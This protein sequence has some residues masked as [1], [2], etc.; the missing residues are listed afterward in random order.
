MIINS[1]FNKFV[2]TFP[3]RVSSFQIRY[4]YWLY[5]YYYYYSLE[6]GQRYTYNIERDE[7]VFT[8]PMEVCKD[9]CRMRV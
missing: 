9:I 2:Y 6:G 3:K 7:N 4:L 1:G 5:Y 8:I